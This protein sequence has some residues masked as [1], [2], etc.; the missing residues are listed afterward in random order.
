MADEMHFNCR[1]MKCNQLWLALQA[2]AQICW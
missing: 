1:R 2:V